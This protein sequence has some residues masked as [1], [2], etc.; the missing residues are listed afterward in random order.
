MGSF[1]TGGVSVQIEALKRLE[2]RADEVCEKAVKAGAE[3]LVERLKEAA[4][5]HGGTRSDVK[6]GT[7]KKSI[8]AGKVTWSATE[9]YSCD[10]GPKGADQH[11]Q[12][13]AKI[14]NVLEYGR[15]NMP[16]RPWFV[17]TVKAAEAEVLRAMQ[18]VLDE[19][20]RE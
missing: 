3:V 17:P 8:K 19:E 10:V 9:G 18:R 6:P 7:L 20:M 4:P 15:S 1:T 14:G 16:A 13:L 12:N 2:K 5:V 11:G